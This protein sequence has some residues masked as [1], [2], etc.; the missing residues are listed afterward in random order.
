LVADRVLHRGQADVPVSEIVERQQIN[1]TQA[2][3]PATLRVLERAY[4][5]SSMKKTDIILET[6]I[7]L[8]SLPEVKEGLVRLD[9]RPE[10]FLAKAEEF[11]ERKPDLREV[12][13]GTV[14][15]DSGLQDWPRSCRQRSRT[16][17]G[18]DT[19]SF[20]PRIYSRP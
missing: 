17:S 20:T 9:V 8:L 5:R 16:P 14:G 13:A 11:L 7:A 19:A 15:K 12:S 10:E 2:V 6:A 1:L 4:E 3:P 18:T